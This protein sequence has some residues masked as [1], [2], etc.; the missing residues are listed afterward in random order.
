MAYFSRSRASHVASA[1]VR[2]RLLSS[3]GGAFPVGSIPIARSI[4]EATPGHVLL[5]VAR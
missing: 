5:L 1:F 3:S 2:N 4:L